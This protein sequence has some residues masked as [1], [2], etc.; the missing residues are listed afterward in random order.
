MKNT[1]ITL[2]ILYIHMYNI[3]KKWGLFNPFFATRSAT[4]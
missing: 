2:K 1:N 3:I 4:A